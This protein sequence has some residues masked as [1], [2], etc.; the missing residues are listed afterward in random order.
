M[1]LI[2]KESVLEEIFKSSENII[3]PISIE[4]YLTFSASEYSNGSTPTSIDLS[5]PCVEVTVPK[6]SDLGDSHCSH[7]SSFVCVDGN[8]EK[9]CIFTGFNLCC[10]VGFTQC[11][12][13]Y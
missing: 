6:C 13:C 12:Y 7:C 10:G 11:V 4:S 9:I 1:G 5:D 3:D 8:W 2:D